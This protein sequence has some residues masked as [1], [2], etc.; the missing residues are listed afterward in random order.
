MRR[1]GVAHA[2]DHAIVPPVFSGAAPAPRARGAWCQDCPNVCFRSVARRGCCCCNLQVA[3]TTLPQMAARTADV[4]TAKGTWP[5]TKGADCFLAFADG[6]KWKH[7]KQA[8]ARPKPARRVVSA[9][10]RP[11]RQRPESSNLSS[12]VRVYGEERPKSQAHDIQ[13][14]RSGT[15]HDR[16]TGTR[17]AQLCQVLWPET[18]LHAP[19]SVSFMSIH[20]YG[21]LIMPPKDCWSALQDEIRCRHAQDD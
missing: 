8:V 10:E 12:F 4:H 3:E 16:A 14:W 17:S 1:W 5:I 7:T 18:G 19:P 13:R 6:G 21:Q 9:H 2:V 20:T 15:E 11:T